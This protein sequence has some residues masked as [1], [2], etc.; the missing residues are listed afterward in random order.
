[1]NN[2][3]LKVKIT[4]LFENS[5]TADELEKARVEIFGKNGLLNSFKKEIVNI[6]PQER[7]DFGLKVNSITQTAEN[8][9]SE[10]KDIIEKKELEEKIKGEKID[11]TMP[12]KYRRQGALHPLSSVLEEFIELFKVFGFSVAEGPE[13][14]KDEYNFD[15]LN[16][17]A[18]HPAR[19]MADTFHMNHGYVLRTHTSPVQVRTMLKSKPPIKIIAPGRVYRKDDLDATHTPVFHQIEGLY[20]DKNVTFA[21]LKAIIT[22]VFKNYYGQDT[23][24]SFRPS[25]FPFT[26]PSA[27]VYVTCSGCGG[28]GE[29]CS[30]CKGTGQIEIIGCGMVHPNVLRKAGIDPEIYSGWAFGLGIERIALRTCGISDIRY[31]YEN[32]YRF[33]RNFE[34]V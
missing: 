8:M 33:L 26:E 15:M 10:K 11:Y 27:E 4:Q 18:N 25:Y 22:G 31:F 17:P 28:S 21:D 20:I 5:N 13:I 2:D 9:F 6:P 16:I 32:D 29:N 12:G 23:E 1:M 3:D 14:E 7:K 30:T 24:V 19:G 34:G